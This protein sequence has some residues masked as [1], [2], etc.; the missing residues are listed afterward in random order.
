MLLMGMGLGGFVRCYFIIEYKS[1]RVMNI[2]I[3][4]V[5]HKYYYG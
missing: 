5:Y 4:N 2:V 1:N 3:R